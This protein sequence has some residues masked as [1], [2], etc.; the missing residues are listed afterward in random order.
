MLSDEGD[1]IQRET[2]YADGP[3]THVVR[4]DS[5]IQ[6]GGLLRLEELAQAIG[7]GISALILALSAILLVRS[8]RRKG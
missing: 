6:L 2:I 8:F 4:L 1:L 7:F 3:S 5:Y